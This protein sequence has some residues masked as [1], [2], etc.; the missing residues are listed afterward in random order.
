MQITKSK[1]VND[2]WSSAWQYVFFIDEIS[3]KH[4]LT[5]ALLNAFCKEQ[6]WSSVETYCTRTVI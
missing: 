1:Y 6:N 5:L 4:K 2:F 3:L